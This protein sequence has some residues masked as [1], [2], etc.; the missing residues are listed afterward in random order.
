VASLILVQSEPWNVINRHAFSSSLP[1]RDGT[2][3][4]LLQ[5]CLLKAYALIVGTGLLSTSWGR[6]LF[7]TA[8]ELY[9]SFL[10][11]GDIRPLR[12]FVVPGCVVLDI[13]ANVGFFTKS[14]AMWVSG[15]GFV[16]AVEPEAYNV[17]QLVRTLEKSHLTRVVRVY[18]VRAITKSPRKV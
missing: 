7:Y 17:K 16:I 12:R 14:F 4:R 13:G 11:A 18:Q 2:V 15:G 1:G 5:S 10:E 6:S 3:N 8:Y 9:K